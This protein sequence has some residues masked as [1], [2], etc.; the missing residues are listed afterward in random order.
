MSSVLLLVF[1]AFTGGAV[2]GARES[3]GVTRGLQ[4]VKQLVS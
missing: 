3:G 4:M 2:S 1:F